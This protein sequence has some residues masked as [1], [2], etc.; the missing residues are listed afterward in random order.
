M[1]FALSGCGESAVSAPPQTGGLA[2]ATSGSGRAARY[3]TDDAS[4]GRYHSKRFLLSF[5]LPD[6]KA[7]KIDDHSRPSLFALHEATGSR[8]HV[9]TTQ[10]DELV[11]RQ[12]C[13]VKARELGWV[14]SK[15]LTTVD[16]EVTI[17]PEAFDS[18]IWVALDAGKSGGG[19]EGHVFLFGAFIRRCL[20][21]HVSTRVASSKDED[22]LSERLA[23][24]RARIVRGLTIDPPRITDD[25]AVPRDKPDIKR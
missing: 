13:E 15:T 10:E 19:L 24:A 25:A 16:D 18:R 20:L 23:L 1:A 6:G 9:I 17:G 3:P 14:E 5:P 12:K 8:V 22:V 21:V 11:N 4:W 2:P 7:W